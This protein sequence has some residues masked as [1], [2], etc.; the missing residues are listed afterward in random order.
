MVI[1]TK[2]S[3]MKE[4]GDSVSSAAKLKKDIENVK[5]ETKVL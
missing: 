4:V 2:V 5:N 1:H 3:N